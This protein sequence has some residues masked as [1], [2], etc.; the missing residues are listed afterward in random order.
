MALMRIKINIKQ[1]SDPI[2]KGLDESP[3]FYFVHSFYPKT[4]ENKIVASTT[5]YG[6]EFTSSVRRGNL[7]A[8][9]FHPEKSQGSGLRLIR[10]FLSLNSEI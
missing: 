8:T 1:K 3:H 5:P 9:Q 6:S 4:N 7:F 2:W 10:N